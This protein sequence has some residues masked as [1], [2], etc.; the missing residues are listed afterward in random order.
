MPSG[1]CAVCPAFSAKTIPTRC[2]PGPGQLWR[3]IWRVLHPD[4]RRAASVRTPMAF[5]VICPCMLQIV[6]RRTGSQTRLSWRGMEWL[7]G[8]D[9]NLRPQGKLSSKKGGERN[10]QKLNRGRT[11]DQIGEITGGVSTS[12]PRFSSPSPLPQALQYGTST[13]C[14]VTTSKPRDAPACTIMIHRDQ[15]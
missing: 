12:S 4:L 11:F 15:A 10:S 2:A 9:L 14:L 8:R 13:L 5:R 3:N 7:R 6:T 1:D